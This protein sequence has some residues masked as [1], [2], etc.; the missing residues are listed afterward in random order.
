MSR[1][2][3]C[4]RCTVGSAYLAGDCRLCWLWHNDPVYQAHWSGQAPPGLWRRVFN[5]GKAAVEHAAAGF[6][7]ADAETYRKRL[8]TCEACAYFTA[9]RGCQK[10]GCRI[11]L[12]ARWREQRCPI[13]KW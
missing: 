8:A 13:G 3:T 10:C 1:P 5:F 2:C 9:A 6:P 4:D 7:Q 11:D 12:K